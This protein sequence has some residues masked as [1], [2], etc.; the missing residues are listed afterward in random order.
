MLAYTDDPLLHLASAECYARQLDAAQAASD[1]PSYVKTF[2]ELDTHR[3]RVG[4][5]SSDLRDHAIGSLTAE[6]FQLH[7]KHNV[8]VFVYY[9]GIAAADKFA[10]RIR[11]SAEHWYDIRNLALLW[12]LYAHGAV[13]YAPGIQWS[14]RCVPR[15]VEW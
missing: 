3:L 5:V 12:H 8:D 6:L 9:S 14:M 13:L 2:N 1:E 4:Y 15:G 10:T 11:E 7:D